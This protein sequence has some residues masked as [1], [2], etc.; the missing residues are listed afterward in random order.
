[1]A[2]DYTRRP[3]PPAAAQGGVSLSKVSLTKS[4]PTVSLTKSGAN[5]G[6]L[7]VNL[8]WSQGQ[9]KKAG[10][11]AKLAGVGTGGVDLDL[12]CLYELANGEKGVIQ[13]LGHAFGSMHGAPH[14]QLDGD[15]R[16]GTVVGGENMHI[17]L[18]KPDV[19]KRILIFAMIYDGAPNWAAVDGVVTLFPA[20][21]PEVEVKLD[22]A[23]GNARI[24]AIALLQN[25]GAGMSVTREV[26]YIDGDQSALDRA[27]GWGLRWA[28]G[29][30]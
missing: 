17:D 1:M 19:F 24:C 13:A 16:T 20:S 25:D 7:R 2:I 29:R 5:Q 30:K 23:G 12:G 14:I 28:A 11:F 22:A 3:R 10:F 27:Y 18:S 15:D 26:Q 21:G 4:A 8:N 6:P 9:P